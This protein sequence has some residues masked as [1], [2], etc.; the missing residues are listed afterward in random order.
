MLEDAY[1]ATDSQFN[2]W[3]IL[4]LC[5]YLV[6]TQK[7]HAVVRACHCVA[8]RDPADARGRGHR[9]GP[10]GGGGEGGG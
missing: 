9:C 5:P 7:L 10:N 8:A 3:V 6:D 1:A 4:G 2:E